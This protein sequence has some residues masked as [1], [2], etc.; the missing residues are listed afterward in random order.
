MLLG[1][2]VIGAWLWSTCSKSLCSHSWQ[3]VEPTT[4]WLQVRCARMTSS[5]LTRHCKWNYETERAMEFDDVRGAGS[6]V[7]S[8][9]VLRD[10]DDTT[11]LT[12][13]P[14]LTL[15]NCHMSLQTS[16]LPLSTAVNG[17]RWLFCLPSFLI[18]DFCCCCYY[19]HGTN[20]T[21]VS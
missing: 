9:D 18:I 4:S 14:R 13:Q 6:S 19:H 1:D 8:I 3:E 11:T 10:D 16:S 12:F 5:S 17:D 2:R 15:G 20:I 7:K 21:P